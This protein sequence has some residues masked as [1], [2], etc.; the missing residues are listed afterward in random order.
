[1]KLGFTKMVGG[2]LRTCKMA[3]NLQSKDWQGLRNQ[4]IISGV[5]ENS[6]FTAQTSFFALY[7]KSVWVLCSHISNVDDIFAEFDFVKSWSTG[8]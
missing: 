4:K 6:P 2:N 7:V 5:G 3:H 1:M 8:M